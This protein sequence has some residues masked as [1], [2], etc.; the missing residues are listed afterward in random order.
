MLMARIARSSGDTTATLDHLARAVAVAPSADLNMMTVSTL[1]EAGRFD[2]A[3]AFI[4]DARTRLSRHPFR[5]Y[6][7]KRNLDELLLY[8]SEAEKLHEDRVGPNKGG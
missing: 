7:G 8:V 1:V 6:S 5:R 4:E 2:H 3:R